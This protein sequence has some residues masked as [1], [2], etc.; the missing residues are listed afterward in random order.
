MTT[1]VLKLNSNKTELMVVAPAPLLRKI[2]DLALVVDGCSISPSPE[3]RNLG[4][5]LE[6]TL[7]LRSHINN[8]TT[9][10]AF[11][12]L[13]NISRLRPSLTHSVTETLIHAFITS[14]LDYCNG[15]LSGLP[16]KALSRLQYVQNSAARVLTHTKP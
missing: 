11:Y 8:I 9:K 7:S 1:N 3:V 15:V 13:R 12:H 16:T 2:G 6:S 5:I 10:S 4:V 14:R